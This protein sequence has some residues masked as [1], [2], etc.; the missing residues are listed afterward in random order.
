MVKLKQNKKGHMFAIGLVIVTLVVCS[1]VLYSF[2]QSSKPIKASMTSPL[3]LQEL[4]NKEANFNFYAKESAKLAE[5][6]AVFE[7][8]GKGG[9][10]GQLC[11]SYNANHV[12]WDDNCNP[13]L[14]VDELFRKYFNLTFEKFLSEYAEINA[15]FSISI[16]DR[17]VDIKSERVAV[18]GYSDGILS[19][20]AEY[21][22]DPSFSY[23]MEIGPKEFKDIYELVYK[24]LAECRDKKD[25]PITS[26]MN[27]IQPDRWNIVVSSEMVGNRYYLIFDMTTKK[28]FYFD[29]NGAKWQQ[30]SL[31][32]AIAI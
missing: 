20:S 6:Q 25:I 32:F 4:Y 11:T 21:S 2:T 15:N 23:G 31:K 18:K 27:Q 14:S 8:S 1:V 3:A 19:Y 9:A 28:R 22:F 16:A 29:D 5:Q 30:V 26:C 13:V 17:K 12:L 24:K 10:S 7:V